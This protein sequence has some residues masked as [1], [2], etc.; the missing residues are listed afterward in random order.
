MAVRFLLIRHGQTDWNLNKRY[1][2]FIDVELNEEGR[3]QAARLGKRLRDE[4]VQTIYASDRKRAVETAQIVFGGAAIEI[5]AGLREINFGCFEGLSHAE[6]ME[7]Y[8][9]VYT[10]WLHDPFNTVI[11]GGESLQDFRL[12][13]VNAFYGIAGAYNDTTVAVVAHGGVLSMLI[14]DVSKTND[15]WGMIPGSAS[16]TVIEFNGSQPRIQLL[17]DTSHLA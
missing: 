10:Q 11:P 13:V 3:K 7:R 8:H 12:R 16:L 15:F 14:N 6:I 2:G 9:D 17:N 5:H 4:K 1:C